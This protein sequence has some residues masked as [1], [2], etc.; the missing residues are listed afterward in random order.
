MAG[1]IERTDVRVTDLRWKVRESPASLWRVLWLSHDELVVAVT[2]IIDADAWC[3]LELCADAPSQRW[4]P[5]LL[6][7]ETDPAAVAAAIGAEL[8]R[9]QDADAR[10]RG[11]DRTT[12][13]PIRD[14]ATHLCQV[15][16]LRSLGAVPD[17]ATID[18]TA[19]SSTALLVRDAMNSTV[20]T[21]GP[22]DTMREA[23]RSMTLHS[24]GAAVVLGGEGP[25]PG[26]LTE[27]DVLRCNGTGGDID[28]EL[29]RDYLTSELVYAEA[30]W[31]VRR[32]A[33]VMVE[34]TFRHVIVL[35]GPEVVGILSM[36]D[37]V[38]CWTQL[39]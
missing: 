18:I 26:I 3:V 30:A 32:A 8:R 17:F 29:V 1:R 13:Q 4:E 37:I 38:R 15:P 11:Y 25:G 31:P 16:P 24:V 9:E 6:L 22:D 23:T 39:P 34:N 19:R 28:A 10:I 12:L 33:E 20:V 27:R 35:D 36:R 7:C 2:T 14:L 5:R 21:V